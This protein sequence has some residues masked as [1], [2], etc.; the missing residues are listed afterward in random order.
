[1]SSARSWFDD[2]AAA[3][4]SSSSS[5]SAAACMAWI[6]LRRIDDHS[7]PLGCLPFTYQDTH[8]GKLAASRIT[9]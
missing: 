3:G 9:Y 8:D 2:A 7:R 5:S 1:M 6:M 4:A